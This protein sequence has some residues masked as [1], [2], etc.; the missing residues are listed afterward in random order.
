MAKFENCR[1]VGEGAYSI[2][3]QCLKGNKLM[4]F[5][6]IPKRDFAYIDTV[7]EWEIVKLLK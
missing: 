2:A 4:C 7:T 5:K 6:I 1:K 3:Y